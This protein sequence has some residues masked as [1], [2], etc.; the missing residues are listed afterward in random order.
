MRL[1]LDQGL[2][3]TAAKLLRE[4]GL[5]ACHVSELGMASATDAEILH[6]ANLANRVVV[7]LD[8]DFHALLALSTASKPSVIRIRME[9][10]KATACATLIRTVITQCQQELAEGC[11]ITVQDKRIRIRLLSAP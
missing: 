6:H 11:M 10:L 7:T 2:P 8:A 1:L 5:D 9:G 3:L 4:A